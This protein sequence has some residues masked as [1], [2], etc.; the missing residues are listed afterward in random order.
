MKRV[1]GF[2]SHLTLG[3]YRLL[4]RFLPRD[5]RK[6]FGQE[7]L[8]LFR[9]RLE[10]GEGGRAGAF[11]DLLLT[12][13]HEHWS[14]FRPG[15]RRRQE[16]SSGRNPGYSPMQTVWKDLFH[17]LRIMKKNPGYAALS[18]LTLGLG[19]GATTVAFSLVNGILL[20]PLPFP[21]PD[22]LVYLMEE[23]SR[24]RE[25]MLSYP[26][27]DDW[28]TASTSFQE[29][30]AVQFAN[31]AS[32]QGGEEP[33]RATVL[34]VSREFFQ[35]LGITPMRGRPIL[36]EE[37][38]PGGERVLVASYEFWTSALGARDDLASL[39][40]NLYGGS[41]QV[42]GVMP[43]G[44]RVLE[45][46]DLYIPM[47]RSP[48][49]IRSAHNYR[50]IGRLAPG[51]SLHQAHEEL[52][53]IAANIKAEYGD[54]TSSEA[55]VMRTLRDA[56]VGEADAPLLLLLAASG[57]LLLIACTNQASNLLARGT[58]RQREM[59][60]RSALGAGRGRLIQQLL[61]E[62]GVLAALGCS[63]GLALTYGT[64]L[65]L[66][67]LGPDLVPRMDAVAVDPQV[68]LFAL[69]AALA[70]SLLFGLMPAFRATEEVS[71][72]LSSAGQRGSTGVRRVAWDLLVG[73]EVAM[74]VVLVTGSGL[75]VRSLQE[76]VGADTGFHANGVLTVALDPS[77]QGFDTEETRSA[78]FRDLQRELSRIPEVA[79]VGMVN[80]LP[81]QAGTWTGPV[82]RSPVSDREDRDEWVAIAGW[83]VA[84]EGYFAAMGI[85]LL[86]G[87]TF[88]P[89]LDRPGGPPV[90]I[91]NRSL[92]ERAFPGEDPLGKQVQA[93]WDRREED[94]TV[95][96][97]VAEARDWRR[98]PG[99][100]P[101]MY[102]YWPQRLEAT[103]YMTAVLRPREGQ[104]I[105]ATE[106]RDAIR[107]VAPSMP[108]EVRAMETLVGESLK[109]RRFTLSVL[110]SFALAALLLSAV[111]TYGVVSYT[112]SRRTREMGIRLALGAR[113]GLLRR[114]IFTRS[115]KV[116]AF[117]AAAGL[118]AA[119]LAG[120]IMEGLLYGITPRD[121]L[122]LAV[123][124][125]VL[126]AIAALAVW[127]P[128]LRYSRVDPA[129]AMDVE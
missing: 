86:A 3:V 55:V 35:V 44:F 115:M 43:P 65:G 24:G 112:V 103:G 85:P 59:A 88:D 123:A 15:P 101:E 63:L 49:D 74:A 100:Q 121:P 128:V 16:T 126:L 53:R 38:R 113:P 120:R 42:V 127:L 83:R 8:D 102:V 122:A 31:V 67:V 105:P 111:G 30:A 80:R 96:G 99:A 25:L 36:P 60:I 2:T 75:L 9:V 11:L 106:V 91:L 54:E 62:G 18:V 29:I 34:G 117:G 1:S 12:I 90:A 69:L 64:L 71:G 98:A 84:D 109:E 41:W 125:L 20:R 94:F 51:F 21:D 82:L 10:R 76:I 23:G 66:R 73:V 61:M 93:L 57:V 108:M 28:R 78:L 40:L 47:E 4:L 92:A 39:T 87:R 27:F 124:P 81:L 45:E 6:E 17:A 68:L 116:V 22:R 52:N 114:R 129:L 32:V 77:G 19:I 70:T 118:G 89:A 97:V 5:F 37:N 50:G 95:V 104:G 110:G 119:L 13:H 72:A 46:A 7:M 58:H 26:N 107:A 56:V 33:T 14:R 48:V 79:T